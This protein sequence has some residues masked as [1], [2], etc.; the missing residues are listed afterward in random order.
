M[1]A[2]ATPNIAAMERLAP[3]GTS[4]ISIRALTFEQKYTKRYACKPMPL[5]SQARNGSNAH[6]AK[7]KAERPIAKSTGSAKPCC[8]K[9]ED[10]QA[11][12]TSIPNDDSVRPPKSA[13]AIRG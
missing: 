13:R 8:A 3:A 10:N 7:A 9:N 12:A 1:D 6:A 4:R 11:S 2:R 5:A